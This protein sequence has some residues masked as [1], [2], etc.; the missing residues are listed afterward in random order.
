[1]K[2]ETLGKDRKIRYATFARRRTLQRRTAMVA[3]G[4]LSPNLIFGFNLRV[5]DGIA[6]L[7]LVAAIV[8]TIFLIRDRHRVD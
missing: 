7:L 2:T 5:M 1:M 8:Q 3:F 4:A 6:M